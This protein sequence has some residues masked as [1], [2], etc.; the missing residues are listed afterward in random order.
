VVASFSI[1]G[2]MTAR[3][4]GDRVAVTTLV[5]PDGDAHVYEPTPDDVRAVAAAR[6]LVVNGLGFEGWMDRLAGA[7]GY[8]GPVVV[9]SKGVAP[10]EIVEEEHADAEGHDHHGIDPHAWQD[11]AN[12]VTYVRNIAAGL[13]AADPAGKATYDANAAA[14][15]AELEA[16]DAEVRAALATLPAERRKIITSHDAF[17]YFG[18]AYGLRLSA[19]EGIS[20][21]AEAS[22]ADV[23][24]LIR[25]IRA[26]AVP[27]IFVENIKDRRLIDQIAAESG[28]A[29]GGELYTDAL[30]DKDGPAPTYVEMIRHNAKTLTE[31]LAPRP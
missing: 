31:A 16:L 7:S 26:D 13:D 11:V 19:P 5:G 6:L 27:A 29:V 14:Y 2:D 24:A 23:A 21:E 15:V 4:G 17:G 1:L 30:S 10:R 9:A 20:T 12:A 3:V 22:A 28:A 25:Q 8:A 18:A